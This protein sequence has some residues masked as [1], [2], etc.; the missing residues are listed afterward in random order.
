MRRVRRVAEVLELSRS[1]LHER[2]RN[3]GKLRL[4]YR[5][6]EDAEL[7]GACDSWSISDPPTVTE[8]SVPC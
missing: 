1:Q 5:K 7:L 3:G 4:R 8:G 2:L 6:A